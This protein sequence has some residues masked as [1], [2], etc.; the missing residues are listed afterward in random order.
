M[1]KPFRDTRAKV[2]VREI[3]SYDGGIITSYLSTEQNYLHL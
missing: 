2:S 3:I 1:S